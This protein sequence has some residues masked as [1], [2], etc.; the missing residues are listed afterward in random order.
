MC[1]LSLTLL[2]SQTVRG[3]FRSLLEREALVFR[4]V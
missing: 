1:L 4:W 3:F 2:S